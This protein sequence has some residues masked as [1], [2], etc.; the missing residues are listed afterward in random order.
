MNLPGPEWMAAAAPGRTVEF[1]FN[2][3]AKARE[4]M[5]QTAASGAPFSLAVL[6][7][8]AMVVV[9]GMRRWTRAWVRE[10]GECLRC[11]YDLRATPGAVC[12]ECGASRKG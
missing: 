7:G 10:A 4:F 1:E 6:S 12:P 8:A 3:W 2:G 5:A 11:G 9:A